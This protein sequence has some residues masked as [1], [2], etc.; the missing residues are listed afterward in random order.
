MKSKPRQKMRLQNKGKIK[1]LDFG[2]GK[3][4]NVSG[5]KYEENQDKE[6]SVD[7]DGDEARE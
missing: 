3:K 1:S 7:S 2:K 4:I 5:N 6:N